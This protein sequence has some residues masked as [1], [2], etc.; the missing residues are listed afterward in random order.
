[1]KDDHDAMKRKRKR[2]E[3]TSETRNKSGCVSTLLCFQ[4]QPN[5]ANIKMSREKK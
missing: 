3:K 4:H 2:T 1:M 5:T